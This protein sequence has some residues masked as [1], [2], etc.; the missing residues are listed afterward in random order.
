MLFFYAWDAFLPCFVRIT[1]GQNFRFYPK[2]HFLSEAFT[3][4][5]AH[6]HT[7]TTFSIGF[8]VTLFNTLFFFFEGFI[9]IPVYV[10][11]Y[12]YICINTRVSIHVY[13]CVVICLMSNYKLSESRNYVSFG[14][15]FHCCFSGA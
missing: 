9:T 2:G 11:V 14:Y 12:A 3:H 10:C 15:F 6:T 13:F 4:K 5:H 7:H 1:P 8:L